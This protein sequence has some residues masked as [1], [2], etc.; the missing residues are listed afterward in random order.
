[1]AAKVRLTGLIHKAFIVGGLWAG[2]DFMTAGCFFSNCPCKMGGYLVI[3]HNKPLL[4]GSQ[5]LVFLP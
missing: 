4:T 5:K 1:V 2:G 3:R